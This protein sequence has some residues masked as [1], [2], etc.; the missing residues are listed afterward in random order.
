MRKSQLNNWCKRL[1]DVGKRNQLMNYRPR[2]SSNLEFYVDDIYSFYNDYTDYKVYEIAKLFKNLDEEVTLSDF[3]DVED[4]YDVKN[5]V[6]NAL[7]TMIEKKNRYTREEIEE[8][9]GR[10]KGNKTKNYLFCETI[11][12][13]ANQ[14]LTLLRR[15]SKTLREE[16]GVES[17]YM[18]FGFVH[19]KDH[20]EYYDA[21]LCLVPSD[22]IQKKIS[23][24]LQIVSTD[25]DFLINQN[26]QYLLKTEYKV[27]INRLDGESF[28]AYYKRLK[29]IFDEIGFETSDRVC[30][31]CF[32]FSKIM[33]YNDLSENE[34][35]I[36]KNPYVNLLLGNKVEIDNK[37][38][39]TSFV[40][41]PIDKQNQVLSADSSQYKAIYFAKHG[42]SFVLQGPPGTGK[43]QTI[44]NI[45]AELIGQGKKVLFVCEK[46]SALEVV[47]NN[48][49]KCGLDQYALPIY[50]TKANKSEVVK[51]IY[52]NIESISKGLTK[53]SEKG[54]K[55]IDK[56]T[57]Y[58]GFLDDYLYELLKKRKPLDKSLYEI[59]N[60][61]LIDA[62]QLSFKLDNLN[63]S[64]KEF[65]DLLEYIDIISI[66]LSNQIE[67]PINNPF[68]GFLTNKVLKKDIALLKTTC[69]ALS[70]NLLKV[71]GYKQEINSSLF[72]ITN[73]D[74]LD[75]YIKLLSLT[76][77]PYDLKEI[78]F[79]KR[80]LQT[81]KKMVKD[82]KEFYNEI[83]KDKDYLES[84]YEARFLDLDVIPD[85][86]DLKEKYKSPLKRLFGYKEII[87][88]YQN[89]L[90]SKKELSYQELID[91]LNL[92]NR[93][94]EK[95]S[96]FIDAEVKLSKDFPRFYF[97]SKTDFTKLTKVIDYLILF[98]AIINKLGNVDKSRIIKDL[99]NS[100]SYVKYQPILNKISDAIKEEL[101]VLFNYFD[102]KY[103]NIN[104][105]DLLVKVKNISLN[106][107]SIYSY[108]DLLKS[109]DKIPLSLESLK[110]EILN[111]DIDTKTLKEAFVKRFN[112]LLLEDI[113]SKD[114]FFSSLD[115]SYIDSTIDKYNQLTSDILEVSKI[116]IRSEVTKSW[117]K[118][119][120][121]T[122]TNLEVSILAKEVNKKKKLMSVRE[123][124][125]N[126]SSLVMSLKPIFMMSPLAVANYLDPEKFHFDCV[127]FDEA[128]QINTEDAIG[129]IYR[130]NQL[131]VVGDKEQLPPTS[132]F[133]TDLEDEEDDN[134]Y[135]SVLDELS[136][137]L[138]SI[139]LKW[140]YRS[141]DESLITYS[142]KE[143]YH[144]LTSFP[145]N[146]ISADL[147]LSYNFVEGVYEA[148][149]R[150]NMIEAEKVVDLLFYEFR[151]NP[152]K[153]IGI[154]TFN[155]SQQY[156]I[157]SLINKRRKKDSAYEQ[158]FDESLKEPFFVKNLE[159]VQGDERDTII[160]STT[161]GKNASGKLNLNFGPINREGGY[162]R[163]NV[164]I[165]RSKQ[166]L[167]LV[168]S[169][170]ASY[171]DLTKIT[172]RGQKMLV[173]FIDYAK[174][175]NTSNFNSSKPTDNFVA[176]L[177]KILNNKGYEVIYNLGSNQY[178]IDL[179]II[180]PNN[181][182]KLKAC[183]LTDSTNYQNLI[184]TRDRNSLI[185]NVLRL[186][187]WKVI[188]LFSSTTFN[189]LE[190]YADLI[191]KE[192]GTD[193]KNELVVE[194]KKEE[195]LEETSE[196]ETLDVYSLF[197]NYPNIVEIIKEEAFKHNDIIDKF[198]N[199]V[200]KTSPIKITE[201]KRLV[202]SPLFNKDLDNELDKQIDSIIDALVKKSVVYKIIGYLLKPSDILNLRFRKYDKLNPYNRD[203][204]SVYIEEIEQGFLTVLNYVK[205]T[206]KTSLFN[207]F[208][209]LLGYPKESKDTNRVF[210][211]VL[212]VLADK[213]LINVS[214]EVIT[215][216]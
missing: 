118:M 116:K 104:P 94:R 25:D 110:N 177:G 73:I 175:R 155:M 176:S 180:D 166:K 21:P 142:N 80:D 127:I 212:M 114:K 117:P 77:N 92:Q 111:N 98:N 201:L 63:I 44:T 130:A 202:S 200:E 68:K 71:L 182:L 5:T 100:K 132:F 51:S 42:L 96:D 163:L 207:T 121:L 178:K 79:L 148:G 209:L 185:D 150:V 215:A 112:E 30:L 146:T 206:T 204:D 9:K 136:A 27:D 53:L 184:S 208:N 34:K 81:S 153:S 55:I 52:Q 14:V 35:L 139:M 134:S 24:A 93:I 56:T 91:D 8:I 11:S 193:T 152:S 113:I 167:I 161:F 205:Q 36:L 190:E 174:N 203:I 102:S 156:L 38:D 74:D 151:H 72:D 78:D 28:E 13:K 66:N 169:L 138:P 149:K 198:R 86:S 145:A 162:R 171:F 108:L 172:N 147:G 140:H 64:K 85:L 88:K 29:K 41:E 75:L 107:D 129:A 105:N 2:L 15:K 1:L 18:C 65:E 37:L 47:H 214:G 69:D 43:S 3:E 186:R 62:P 59:I 197:D 165:T 119:N 213:E 157:W 48:L 103:I 31:G 133:D 211:R 60:D 168:T 82:V 199:I 26:L 160:L 22:I 158:F 89:L 192:I 83:L 17:L 173:G 123:L 12:S 188:H 4:P 191:I 50:D 95:Y 125:N 23:D 189:R 181:P 106:P 164:A 90:I 196:A 49:K 143:I 137:I 179:A 194:E 6:T 101:D 32:S 195:V 216:L 183:I 20:K 58:K 7:G 45:L 39:D 84:K 187:G 57:D 46:S 97:G 67:A 33:M 40:E 109:L 126:T 154:V 210:N 87:K 115:E 76:G 99:I 120:S 144:D 10:F 16:N 141:Q 131:I 159:T 70:E 170:D 122:D 61:S 135:E 124:L 128:S 19:Y 54:Q